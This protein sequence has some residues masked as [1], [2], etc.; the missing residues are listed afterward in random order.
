VSKEAAGGTFGSE[1]GAGACAACRGPH[2]RRRA[3]ARVSGAVLA[4]M[5]HLAAG[6]DAA[7][8]FPVVEGQGAGGPDE[9][10][11]PL[12]PGDGVTI[13]R[14][15]QV[16]LVRFRGSV[17]AFNLACPHENTALRWRERDG[18]FQCPRHGSQYRPDGTFI[19]GRATRGMD[20]FALR[21]SGDELVVDTGRLLRSDRQPQEWASAVLAL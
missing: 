10:R 1:D 19:Q 6:R 18:R 14:A 5:A 11:Y 13:D 4:A 12:P 7:R 16:I 8:A 3:L 21:R 15:G 2:G 9:R 17:F 20:R